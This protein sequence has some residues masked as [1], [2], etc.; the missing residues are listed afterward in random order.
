MVARAIMVQGTASHVGKSVIATAL[1]RILY[2]DGYRV[3]PFKAQ[4]MALNSY[5]TRDGGEIGRAQVVQAE[6]AEVEP[7]VDMNPILLKPCSDKGCQVIIHGKVYRNMTGQ[8]YY[9]FK[10]QAFTFVRDSYHRLAQAFDVIVIEGAG[11]PAEINL[12]DWDIV[13]M[14]IAEM[15][16]SP[17]LLVAN[18]DRGGVFASIVGTMELLSEKERE[19]VKGYIINK[20]RGDLDLLGPGLDFLTRRTGRPVLGVIPYF[21][22]ITLPGEV[23]VSLENG[24]GDHEAEG[25]SVR[26]GVIRLPHISNYTDFD[27]LTREPGVSLRYL[28]KAEEVSKADVVVIPGSKNTIDDLAYLKREGFEE[29][30]LRH[31]K[32]G[33]T[34]VGICGGFQMLGLRVED[35]WGME[36]DLR[37]VQGLGLLNAITTLDRDK[38]TFQV[39]AL[40]ISG[41]YGEGWRLE[42]YEIHLGTTHIGESSLPFLKVFRRD[43]KGT[44]ILDGAISQDG[45]VWGTYIHGIFDHPGFRRSFLNAIREEK[46]LPPLDSLLTF[47][48][49]ELRRRQ[50]D[51]LAR[52][53]RNSLKMERV[54][55][56]MGLVHGQ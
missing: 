14:R 38:V 2:Q 50:Y 22:D 36:S 26:I 5:P 35:P 55:Q 19:R 31:H 8:E 37:E 30:I 29:A 9:A 10:D 54:F 48:G 3:A 27:P 28:V 7:I 25:I 42:G 4:N 53:V 6:A 56:I 51:E 40:P 47:N 11:S 18:I 16:D 21:K 32:T 45:K 46:G 12:K 43:G 41:H 39:E 34:I 49:R 52:L 33:G 44:V 13:N 23:S 24:R 17:V 1:C 20:F 15:A